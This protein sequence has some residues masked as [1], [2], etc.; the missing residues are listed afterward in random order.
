MVLAPVLSIIGLSCYKPAAMLCASNWGISMSL[1]AVCGLLSQTLRC[2]H[3]P[4]CTWRGGD[5]RYAPVFRM[6]AM[7]LPISC[8]WIV[9]SFWVHDATDYPS[10]VRLVQ[11]TSA[12]TAENPHRTLTALQGNITHLSPWFQFPYPGKEERSVYLIQSCVILSA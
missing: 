11:N 12:R 5:R 6:L 2:V 7:F 3:L 9:C 4:L 10:D 8:I 1:I